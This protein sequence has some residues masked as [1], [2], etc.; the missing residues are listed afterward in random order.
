MNSPKST[1]RERLHEI[2]F[3]ADTPAGRTFDVVLLVAI[4]LSVLTVILESVAGIQQRYGAALRSIEWIFT[5]LFSIEYLMRLGCVRRPLRYSF[6]FFGIVDL[7]ALLPT[8][9][10]LVI[11]GAQSLLVIRALR[12]LRIFRVMKIAR[13]LSELSALVEAV[14][15]TRT[16]ITVFVMV[17]M[18]LVLIMGSAMYVVEGHQSGFTS[19][20][21]GIY[22]AIVTVTTVGYGDIAPRTVM[23]QVIAAIAMLLGYSLIIIPTGIFSTELARVTNKP[24][25]TQHCPACSKEG[26]DIDATH[27]KYCGEK[28]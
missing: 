5:V 26:H 1:F 27:C 20:P 28:L 24:L 7:F 15:A 11:P 16:K 12:L 23:G 21:R 3:E 9:L 8:Y 18:T 13:H 22:W 17:V 19:I 10:S 6:S 25:T 4:S 14:K 2:I